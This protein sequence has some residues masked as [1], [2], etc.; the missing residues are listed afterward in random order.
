[1][2]KIVFIGG[3]NMAS[4]LI[5]GMLA[6]GFPKQQILVSEPNNASRERIASTYGVEVTEDNL[7]AV[8]SAQIILLAVKPQVMSQVAQNLASALSHQPII[9]SIAAGVPVSALQSWLGEQLKIVRAMPNTPAMVQTGATGLFANQPLSFE[10][11]TTVESIFNAVGYCCW[12][13]NEG[14]IDAVT[15]VSGSGPAYFFLVYEAMQKVAQELGLDTSTAEKLTLHTALG[16]AQL[17]LSSDKPAS[18][19]RRQVTSPGGTTQAAVESFQD[20]GIEEIFRRA[21]N[22]AADRALEMAKDLTN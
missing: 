16:A 2:S 7:S 22:S 21:M 11:Q 10:E 13:E 6:K 12:V 5:G 9:V 8:S 19:L 17:A 1:M 15:A 20:Q 3:G 4:C 18:E 14:L